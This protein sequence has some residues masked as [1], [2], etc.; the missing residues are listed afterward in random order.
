MYQSLYG[1]AELVIALG[2]ASALPLISAAP[3]FASQISYWKK[4]FWFSRYHF[5]KSYWNFTRGPSQRWK[6][7]LQS[8]AYD[9][10]AMISK[11]AND[12]SKTISFYYDRRSIFKRIFA[13]VPAG[14]RSWLDC[15]RIF[16]MS[17]WWRHFFKL[18]VSVSL[19]NWPWLQKWSLREFGIKIV[20]DAK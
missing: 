12:F 4:Y 9:T 3:V 20:F 15:Y 6:A 11:H 8:G 1:I 13:L 5:Q 7:D 16:P 17:S 19:P 18:N 2:S 10:R 14:F